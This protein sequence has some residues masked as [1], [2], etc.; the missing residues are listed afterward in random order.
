MILYALGVITGILLVLILFVFELRNKT[1]Y[2]PSNLVE[3]LRDTV[4]SKNKPK[5]SIILPPS[6]LEFAQNKKIKENED[7][8]LDTLLDEIIL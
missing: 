3:T 2:K 6:D 1:S 4:E 7:K 8:G 5:G